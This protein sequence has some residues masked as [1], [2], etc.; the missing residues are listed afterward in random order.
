M[1]L[2][3]IEEKIDKWLNDKSIEEWLDQ[4]EKKMNILESQIDRFHLKCN[5]I[6]SFI[7]VVLLKYK[8]EGY[9]RRWYSRGMMPQEGLLWFLLSYAEK[10][11]RMADNFE[12][13]EYGNYFMSS[14]FKIGSYYIG[15]MHGQ[16][17]VVHIVK[18]NK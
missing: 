6:D 8:S 4:H 11:G 14:L 18:E 9:K 5:D 16:G 17:A 3:K 10:Y 15:A 13:E 7:E 12:M 1:N 2:Q